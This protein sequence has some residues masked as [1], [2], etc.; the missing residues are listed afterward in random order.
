MFVFGT[1]EIL[2]HEYINYLEQFLKSSID[3]GLSYSVFMDLEAFGTTFWG[4]LYYRESQI[5]SKFKWKMLP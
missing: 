4:L 5:F 3:D 2:Y 1:D